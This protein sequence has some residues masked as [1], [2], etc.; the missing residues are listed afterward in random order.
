VKIL[1][2]LPSATE[3]G[4][5]KTV[6]MRNLYG[7]GPGL[8][9]PMLAAV[10]PA[11]HEVR[12]V[13]EFH[14]EIPFDERFDLVGLSVNTLNA[15]S[16]Y[17]AAER[18]RQ[19]G[20]PVV[21]GGIHATAVPNEAS[22]HGDA[23]VV[24]EGEAAWPRVLADATAGRLA[25][26]YGRSDPLDLASLPPPRVDLL[27]LGDYAHRRLGIFQ[28]VFATRGCPYECAFCSVP[29]L[30]GKKMRLKPVDGVLR[31]LRTCQEA[32]A[33]LGP[34]AFWFVDDTLDARRSWAKELFEAMIPL[35]IRWV[36]M[37]SIRAAE[38]EELLRLARVAGCQ[39]LFVGIESVD[40]ET[41]ESIGKVANLRADYG[42]LI[43]RFRRH[44]LRLQ[45][46]LI[47]GFPGDR[48]ESF[49][50][51]VDMLCEHHVD[52]G[53]FHPLIPF[54]GTVLYARFREEGRLFNEEFWLDPSTSIFRIHRLDHMDPEQYEQA[55]WT[56]MNR[57]YSVGSIARRLLWP[58]EAHNLLP[59]LVI[60][61]FFRQQVRGRHFGMS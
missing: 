9:L 8:G 49:F 61:A 21:L 45:T 19:K 38:D 6:K 15:H 2:V 27:A 50:A 43:A 35:G 1:L 32:A 36:A 58:P 46:G 22:L 17:A 59:T 14:Q 39:G 28:S 11:E 48:P 52:I 16:A 20:I 5:G 56:A 60:N 42:R 7:R 57:F 53:Y 37:M 33:H 51:A 4:T 55:Y 3:S 13:E 12:I 54:P 44:G 10:T 31:D 23:V 30:Y 34:V 29:S 41:L 24:G 25:S 40:E 47:F 26:V 18:F